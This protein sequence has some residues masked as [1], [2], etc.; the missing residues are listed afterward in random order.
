MRKMLLIT[1]FVVIG[2]FF[3]SCS[4]KIINIKSYS[5]RNVLYQLNNNKNFS[6]FENCYTFFDKEAFTQFLSKNFVPS[7]NMIEVD[8]RYNDLILINSNWNG[9]KAGLIYKVK[10]II[11]NITKSRIDI[12]IIKDGKGAVSNNDGKTKFE[13]FLCIGIPKDAD[14]VEYGLSINR[15]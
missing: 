15:K 1:L 11:R 7:K 10:S 6:N 5:E 8:F 14:L 4:D 13:E 9:Y 12:T 2:M 3:S